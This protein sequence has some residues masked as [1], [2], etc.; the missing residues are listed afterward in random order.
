MKEM[1]KKIMSRMISLNIDDDGDGQYHHLMTFG[2]LENYNR[3]IIIMITWHFLLMSS[4]TDVWGIR[5]LDCQLICF[6]GG[7]M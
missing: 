1:L 6:R 3:L 5:Y 4:K 2:H 7:K